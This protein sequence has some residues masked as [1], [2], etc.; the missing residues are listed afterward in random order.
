M[1]DERMNDEHGNPGS[2]E[3]AAD[4]EGRLAELQARLDEAE[5]GWRRAAA[6]FDNLR[7]RV[8]RD[9]DRQRAEERVRVAREWL[10]VLDNLD[11]ALEHATS[12]PS[13]IVAGV[14]AVRDQAVAILARLGFPR[15]DE[16]GEVFDPGRHEAVA[17]VADAQAR[18][19]TVLHVVR[20]GYGD[21]DQQLRP[22]SV[23]VA[24]RAD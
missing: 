3:E 18:A 7:K 15:R 17:T 1:A 20:P 21:D 5:D 13:Q 10:P 23:V 24:T 12:D 6:D 4:L 2:P 11:R 8:L 9:A 19:G 22:A 16:V 14:K